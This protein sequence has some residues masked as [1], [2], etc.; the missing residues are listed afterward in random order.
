LND[1]TP[2]SEYPHLCGIGAGGVGPQGRELLLLLGICCI[3]LPGRD[4]GRSTLSYMLFLFTSLGRLCM[5]LLSKTAMALCRTEDVWSH[6]FRARGAELATD[7]AGTTEH[8]GA[9][10][11]YLGARRLPA[12]SPVKGLEERLLWRRRWLRASQMAV[13]LRVSAGELSEDVLQRRTRRHFP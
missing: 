11:P 8:V 5:R 2:A 1:S 10:M 4:G 12:L 9:A 6:R 7:R 3:A 13:R